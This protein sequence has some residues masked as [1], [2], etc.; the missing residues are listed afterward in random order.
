MKQIAIILGLFFYACTVHATDYYLSN[1]G[2][3]SHSGTSEARAWASMDRLNQAIPSMQPGD[4]V[5]F[6]RGGTYHGSLHIQNVWGNEARPITFGAYGSGPDP[7]IDG[8]RE[9]SGWTREG[10]IWTSQCQ[11]CPLEIYS[12]FINDE[13]QP[14][15]RY[16][17]E[18]SLTTSGGSGKKNG[19][20]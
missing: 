3:D 17:N 1:S 4:R 20:L 5:F 13:S 9:V 15:G 14:L 11:D 8:T 7:I 16:P 10:N 2:M 12:L 18:T 19:L 6:E